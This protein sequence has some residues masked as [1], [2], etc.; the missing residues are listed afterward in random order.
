MTQ[1]EHDGETLIERRPGAVAQFPMLG[2]MWVEPG[3]KADWDLL[4]ELHYKDAERLP[5]GPTYWKLTLEGETIGVIL[6][7]QPNPLLKERNVLLKHYKPGSQ[8]T[9]ITNVHRYK[10][11]NAHMTVISRFVLDTMYRGIGAGYRFQNLVSRL[12]NRR[13]VE[14]QSSMAKHNLFAQKAGFRFVNPM[15]ANRFEEGVRFFRQH[16]E[17]TPQDFEGLVAELEAMPPRLR[18]KT[19]EA[20][21]NFYYKHSPK[22][23]TGARR[24]TGLRLVGERSARQLIRDLQQLVLAS[25][26]YGIFENPDF[27]REL[28][29][30]LPLTAFDRQ[31]PDQPLILDGLA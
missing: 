15:N 19:T 28:P 2:Q 8:D 4:H 23:K 29:K 7:G 27:G 17:T 31:A 9:H 18:E 3:S 25:P 12:S 6:L 22:E 30:R 26:L 5:V 20:V 14:I 10:W 24:E 13:F 11:V 1:F 21:R 16:F